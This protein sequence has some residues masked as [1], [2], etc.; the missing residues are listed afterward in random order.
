MYRGLPK[1]FSGYMH[2]AILQQD[3]FAV[4][5][6]H[7]QVREE[8]IPLL[9]DIEKKEKDVAAASLMFGREAA[10]RGYRI[11]WDP[12]IKIMRQTSSR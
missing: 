11:L 12:V 2:R 10:A 6:R 1:Q 8:L 4:D 7:I 3:V 9:K 5:I